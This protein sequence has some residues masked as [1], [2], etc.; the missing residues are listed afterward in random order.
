[1][2]GILAVV[3]FLLDII[4][5]IDALKSS[6]ETGKKVLWVILIFILPVVGLILYY[7]VGKKK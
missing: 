4:A 2:Q 7:L 1:M 6:L 5:I 3:I